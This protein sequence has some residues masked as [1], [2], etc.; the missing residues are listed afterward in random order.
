MDDNTPMTYGK[1][2]GR[3]MANVPADYLLWLYENGRCSQ[4]VKEY[5][6]DNMDVLRQ[7]TAK[8]QTR[9]CGPCAHQ[10]KE[11][12]VVVNG[13]YLKKNW[14]HHHDKIVEW[15]QEA[16]DDYKKRD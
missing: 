11:L 4:P 16:C 12:A 8:T 6:E 1:F 13:R 5:I 7:E 2:Q 3:A 9:I 15:E 14:C 10:W